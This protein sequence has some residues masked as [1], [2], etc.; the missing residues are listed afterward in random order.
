MNE[1]RI[2]LITRGRFL[3]K[4][5]EVVERRR[6]LL[7]GQMAMLMFE[8]KYRDYVLKVCFHALRQEKETCK[9]LLLQDSLVN[10][11]NPAIETVHHD[12]VQKGAVMTRKESVDKLKI[13]HI[14]MG[15]RLYSYFEHWKRF[16]EY[17][18]QKVI[19]GLRTRMVGVNRDNI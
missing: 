16:A 4:M 10:E 2:N 13:A 5:K 7:R 12:I 3:K 17:K 14:M 6:Y 18:R 15:R 1:D 8:N 11:M 19:G 9:A